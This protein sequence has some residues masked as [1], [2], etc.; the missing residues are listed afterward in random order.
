ML[1]LTITSP[2]PLIVIL[3]PLIVDV[4]VLL[5]HD[6]GIAGL[7]LISSSAVTCTFLAFSM[8]LLHLDDVLTLDVRLA[9]LADR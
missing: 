4:A 9:V 3:P 1:P 8:L 7:E 5:H 6:L 2:L